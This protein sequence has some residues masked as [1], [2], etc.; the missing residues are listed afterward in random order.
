M[1]WWWRLWWRCWWRW[2]MIDFKLIE[3]F[4][5][6]TDKCTDIY[7]CWVAFTLEQKGVGPKVHK[8]GMVISRSYFNIGAWL[9]RRSILFNKEM[10]K[11]NISIIHPSLFNIFLN[12]SQKWL[13]IDCPFINLYAPHEIQDLNSLNAG[14]ITIF[15]S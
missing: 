10:K 1:I 9:Y 6:W 14:N 4:W 15:H 2:W 5:R 8:L 13:N 7:N 3:G 12:Q 11:S